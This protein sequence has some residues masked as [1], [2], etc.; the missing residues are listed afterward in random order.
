VSTTAEADQLIVTSLAV[1]GTLAVLKK[2]TAGEPPDVVRVLIGVFVAGTMLTL[3]AQGAPQLASSIAVL[4]LIAALIYAGADVF[5][6]IAKTTGYMAPGVKAP[7]RFN[8]GNN[9]SVF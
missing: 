1:T 7:K 2:V 8:I 4:V 9:R 6:A 3:A 5:G